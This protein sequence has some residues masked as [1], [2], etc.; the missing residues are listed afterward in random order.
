[1]RPTLK[2]THTPARIT[3]TQTMVR[4]TATLSQLSI[5]ADAPKSER[6]IELSDDDFDLV[7]VRSAHLAWLNMHLASVSSQ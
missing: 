5:T 1:M 2:Q 3:A 6:T 7:Q 4:S